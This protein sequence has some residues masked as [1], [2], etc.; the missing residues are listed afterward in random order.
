MSEFENN[1][2]NNLKKQQ[3]FLLIFT[4]YLII[5]RCNTKFHYDPLKGA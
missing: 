1:F 2:G 3:H 4:R 5:A